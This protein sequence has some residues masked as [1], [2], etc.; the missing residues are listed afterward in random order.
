M[1]RRLTGCLVALTDAYAAHAE[2]AERLKPGDAVDSAELAFYP[3]RWQARKLPS[4]LHPWRGKEVVLLDATNDEI[5]DPIRAMRIGRQDGSYGPSVRTARWF[6]DDQRNPR[7]IP[8]VAAS[9]RRAG[10]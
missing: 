8:E 2:D 5:L 9:R 3:K 1:H 6:G 4:K 10:V 7:T